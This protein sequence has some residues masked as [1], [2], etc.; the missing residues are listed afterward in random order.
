MQHDLFKTAFETA[1]LHYEVA[2]GDKLERAPNIAMPF[3]PGDKLADLRD[4]LIT[5][6]GIEVGAELATGTKAELAKELA[7][8]LFVTIGTCVAY[9]IPV[10]PCFMAVFDDNM[11]RLEKGTLDKTSGKLK[12]PAGWPKLDLS[13]IVH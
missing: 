12:K 10:M 8:L 7:D 4:L 3:V 13:G 2:L 9:D 1:L 6:E 5:E 11:A